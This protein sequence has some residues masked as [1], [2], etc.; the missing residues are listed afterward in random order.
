MFGFGESKPKEVEPTFQPPQDAQEKIA[1]AF[2]F[3]AMNS[4]Q[5]QVSSLQECA[6]RNNIIDTND[7][8]QLINRCGR[9]VQSLS[10]CMETVNE[11]E[12]MA[13][14]TSLSAQQC[15]SQFQ[16]FNSCI[17]S[18]PNNHGACEGVFIDALGC[19]ADHILDMVSQAQNQQSQRKW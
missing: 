2:S 10:S 9:E 1:M 7:E 11:E 15:P 18:N 4:C 14:L 13:A 6:E 12:V 5:E 3:L 19:A 8:R 17:Q 16:R